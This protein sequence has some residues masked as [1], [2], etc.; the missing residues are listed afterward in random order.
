MYGHDGP[1]E[2]LPEE[3]V[4]EVA[5]LLAVG[6]LRMRKRFLDL[7]DQDQSSGLDAENIEEINDLRRERP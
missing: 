3:R 4:S 1:E 6:Y 7:D 2:L 5:R